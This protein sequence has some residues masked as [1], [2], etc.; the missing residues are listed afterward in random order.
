MIAEAV[1]SEFFFDSNRA[2]GARTPS[3]GLYKPKPVPV[4]REEFPKAVAWRTQDTPAEAPKSLN[5]PGVRE[6]V[7]SAWRLTQARKLA[8]KA[9]QDLAAKC[10]TLGKTAG[11]IDAGLVAARKA[12]FA[13]LPPD[14]QA[15]VRTF[16]IDDVA[17]ITRSVLPTS[18][19]QGAVRE[20]TL[21]RDANTPFPTI[22]MVATLLNA[23]DSPPSTTVV[24]ADAPRDTYYVA[25][26]V[27]RKEA[28]P[29]TFASL[30]YGEQARGSQ[31]APPVRRAHQEA[32]RK[33]MRDDA[34]LL[35]R[36]E[37]GYSGD[38]AKL[39][40]RRRGDAGDS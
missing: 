25:T 26:L 15:K 34:A 20:F 29:G 12:A 28:D 23:K 2:T 7:T 14:A 5:G 31:L 21:Q 19:G 35:L 33:Q 8:E 36:S 24:M 1:G 9:A 37:F 13:G 10:Q 22:E 40:A 39:D 30:V 17:P 6:K 11:E 18:S 32:L 4:S 16:D 38:D 27:Y 3:V